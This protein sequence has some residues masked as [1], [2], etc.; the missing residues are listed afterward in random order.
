LD[1]GDEVV[2]TQ[3]ILA[4]PRFLFLSNPGYGGR[5]ITPE[6]YACLAANHTAANDIQERRPILRPR[7]GGEN[8][9]HE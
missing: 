4:Y 9:I 3:P 2:Y 1:F 6:S 5:G 7:M 8:H